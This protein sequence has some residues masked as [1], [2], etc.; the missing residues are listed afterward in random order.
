MYVLTDTGGGKLRQGTSEEP[1]QYSWA[2]VKMLT[3]T[4]YFSFL[5][6]LVYS[7]AVIFVALLDWLELY[8]TSSVG[9]NSIKNM[10]A[11]TL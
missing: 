8:A 9:L 7:S 5:S 1:G 10:F 3:I 11:P 6:C 4:A 2:W